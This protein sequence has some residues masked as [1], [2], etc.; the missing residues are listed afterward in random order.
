MSAF[1]A[2]SLLSHHLIAHVPPC[3]LHNCSVGRGVPRGTLSLA[4]QCTQVPT[5]VRRL[6][7]L[8]ASR[9]DTHCPTHPDDAWPRPQLC[10]QAQPEECWWPSSDGGPER[11]HPPAPHRMCSRSCTCAYCRHTPTRVTTHRMPLGVRHASPQDARRGCPGCT[12]MG[13][14]SGPSRC[15]PGCTREATQGLDY[16]LQPENAR[17]AQSPAEPHC[18]PRRPSGLPQLHVAGPY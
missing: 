2:Y 12:L 7:S 10:R 15:G 13:A 3:L 6:P 5:P 9:P 1:T 17:G 11:L 18:R 14:N 4:A 16:I 8:P